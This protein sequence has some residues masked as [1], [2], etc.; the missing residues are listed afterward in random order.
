MIEFDQLWNY[1]QPA[2]TEKRFRELLTEAETSGDKSYHAQLLTQIARTQ[3]LQRHFD[4]AHKTLDAVQAMLTDDLTTARIRYLLERGRVFNS[5]QKR[6]QA[7]PLFLQ[8]WE[9]AQ[10]VDEDGYAVDAA[11]MIAIVE[12]APDQQLEWNLKALKL[13]ESSNQPGAQ[14]WLGSLYNNIGWTYHDSGEYEKALEIF[15]KAL[16]WREQKGDAQTIFIARWCIGRT[17]RSLGRIDEALAVQRG[18]LKE[19]EAGASS[20]GYVY[21][22]LGELLLLKNDPEAP[23]YFQLAYDQ[24]AGDAWF[25]AN[26]SA[27]L[28]R[29]KTL[30]N[31]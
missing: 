10:S 24:L 25:A 7:R 5:S 21:E 17:L 6:D 4:S 16:H 2:E 20:D 18:L 13:A 23:R 14:K 30:G 29:L 22:E 9:L 27:R 15:Q 28:E 26:E 12:S 8:A 19:I 3:G 31:P 1:N 11:H